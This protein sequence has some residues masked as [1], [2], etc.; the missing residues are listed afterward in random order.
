MMIFVKV[1]PSAK[2]ERF[3]EIDSFLIPGGQ[4]FSGRFFVAGVSGPAKEGRA[5][6]ALVKLA[7][8]YFKVS[9]SSV[10]IVSGIKSRNKILE[11]Y[12]VK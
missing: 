3:E 11:I 1:K 10:R 7:A 5:N 6:E 9:L 2:K 8:D 4:S 12:P